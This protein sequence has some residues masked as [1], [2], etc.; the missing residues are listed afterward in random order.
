MCVWVS[1][2]LCVCVTIANQCK[3]EYIHSRI[4]IK[5]YINICHSVCACCTC[6]IWLAAVFL[7]AKY[8]LMYI[9][10]YVNMYIVVCIYIF[11]HTYDMNLHFYSKID[12][13][14][15]THCIYNNVYVYTYIHHV[16]RC[17]PFFLEFFVFV[18]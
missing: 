2:S 8:L 15:N 3:F 6:R 5:R 12:A 1:L 13:Y 9:H 18:C 7:S 16:L 4:C 10:T 17:K 11:M 14:I